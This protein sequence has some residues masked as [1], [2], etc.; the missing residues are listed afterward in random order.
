VDLSASIS[1]L[2]LSSL[3]SMSSAPWEWVGDRV[4]ER[5]REREKEREEG[6][7]GP[8]D[9]CPCGRGRRGLAMHVCG[10]AYLVGEELA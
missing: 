4:H 3:S 8:R 10:V 7:R 2:T 6:S 9:A 1:T 5:E